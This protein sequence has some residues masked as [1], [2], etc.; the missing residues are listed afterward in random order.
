[1]KNIVSVYFIIDSK[2]YGTQISG[3]NSTESHHDTLI[4]T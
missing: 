2:F 4:V 3:F 1:M